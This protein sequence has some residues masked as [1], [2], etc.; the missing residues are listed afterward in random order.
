MESIEL[1]KDIVDYLFSNVDLM[2]EEDNRKLITKPYSVKFSTDYVE[3]ITN[4]LSIKP[5]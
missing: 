5:D 4:T 1:S 3:Q 2:I